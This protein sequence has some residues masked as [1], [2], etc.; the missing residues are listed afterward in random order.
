M[1]FDSRWANNHFTLSKSGS[2]T[3]RRHHAGPGEVPAVREL[4]LRRS[5][6]LAEDPFAKRRE[7][8]LLDGHWDCEQRES[9]QLLEVSSCHWPVCSQRRTKN[10]PGCSHL[11][12]RDPDS[13][14]VIASAA[15]DSVARRQKGV[16]ALDELRI[17]GK[18]SRD[19][20]DDTGCINTV[21]CQ[22]LRMIRCGDR[23]IRS[24][25]EVFHNV[26]ESV[27]NIWVINKLHFDLVKVA[28]RVL[29]TIRWA[30][31]LDRPALA[32]RPLGPCTAL[33]GT[34]TG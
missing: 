12:C 5:Q 21:S 29:E 17:A 27:I 28:Q 11:V 23:H 13:I 19:T 18:K 15:L 4:E 7:L 14:R 24:T 2:T 26:Q 30:A 22:H 20:F 10:L 34:A 32:N 3:T 9:G 8:C 33:G 16:E 31:G 6:R 25:L 1:G